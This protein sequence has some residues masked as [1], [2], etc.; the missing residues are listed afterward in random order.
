MPGLRPM[1]PNAALAELM[2]RDRDLEDDAPLGGWAGEFVRP[3]RDR[4]RP[5]PDELTVGDSMNAPTEPQPSVEDEAVSW[6]PPAGPGTEDLVE[7]VERVHAA[8]GSTGPELTDEVLEALGL[9][10][11]GPTP[12]PNLDRIMAER[13]QEGW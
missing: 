11:K 2:E 3:A 7:P 13:A 6:G 10:A 4:P 9:A 1:P 12:T 8:A 5:A